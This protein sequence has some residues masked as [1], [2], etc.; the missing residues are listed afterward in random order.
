MHMLILVRT[1]PRGGGNIL[2]ERRGG[3]VTSLN[4]VNF[5]IPMTK[6]IVLCAS[7]DFFSLTHSPGLLQ[8]RTSV[9]LLMGVY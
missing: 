3:G 1:F 9:E 7:F 4:V 5:S 2:P 6:S 8:I